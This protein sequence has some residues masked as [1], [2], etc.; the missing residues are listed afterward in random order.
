MTSILILEKMFENCNTKEDLRFESF[1][2]HRSIMKIVP[3]M[4]VLYII[5]KFLMEKGSLLCIRH[6]FVF[7]NN[8]KLVLLEI[9]DIL[10]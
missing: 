9:S 4:Y 8:T 2:D 5:F 10:I 6:L 1:K 3:M 7:Q